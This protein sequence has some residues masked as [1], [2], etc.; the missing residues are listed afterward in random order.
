MQSL[1]A[2]FGDVEDVW[3][4]FLEFHDL[5]CLENVE[6]HDI[7]AQHEGTKARHLGRF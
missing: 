2:K 3:A 4:A 1:F 7:L 6:L 5:S